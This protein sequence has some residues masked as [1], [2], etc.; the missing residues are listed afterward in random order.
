[1]ALTEGSTKGLV[2]ATLLFLV[3]A[4][5]AQSRVLAAMTAMGI[6]AVI[7]AGTFYEHASY[8]LAI[9]HPTITIGLFS[10]LGAAVFAVAGRLPDDF[11]PLAIVFSR[12]CLLIVNFGFWIGSL[13]GDSLRSTP[14]EYYNP[15]QR[16]IPGWVFA[17]AWAV[18]LLAVGAW[19]IRREKR[20]VVNLAA[21]FAAIHFYT[22]WFERLG[23]Q[24]L[25]V[26]VGGLSAIAIAL[27]LLKYNRRAVHPAA[28]VPPPAS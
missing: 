7:G 14:G 12:T 18:G 5:L 8:G 28:I 23:A 27:G 9:E 20:F 13:W 17:V 24:P 6:L 3:G 1:M 11:E 10:L 21:T 19:G 2:L 4:L 22:Q 16:A 26:I 15:D 25:S